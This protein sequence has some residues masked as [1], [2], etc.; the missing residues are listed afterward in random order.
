MLFSYGHLAARAFCAA[1]HFAR[2]ADEKRAVV[3]S[4][5]RNSAD[6]GGTAAR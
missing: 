2:G 1:A 3:A 4:R 5:L 6:H